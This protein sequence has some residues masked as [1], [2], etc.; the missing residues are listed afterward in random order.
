MLGAYMSVTLTYSIYFKK[1]ALLDTFILASLFTLRIVFGIVL[2]GVMPSAWLLVFFLFLFFSLSL[3]KRHTEVKASAQK[4]GGD[5]I[6]GRGYIADDEPL[7]LA[8]GMASGVAAVLIMVLYIMNDAIKA[9]FYSSPEFF[10]AFPCLLFLWI[11]RIWLLGQR[12]ELHDDPVAFAIKDRVSR[13]L[14]MAMVASFLATCFLPSL[15]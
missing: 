1:V 9:G 10:W 7:L 14:G 11:G 6:A 15:A 3:A 12:G 2:T 13:W 8:M 5:K 4:A